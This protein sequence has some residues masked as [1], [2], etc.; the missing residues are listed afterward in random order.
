LL[1][2]FNCQ[3]RPEATDRTAPLS[4]LPPSTILLASYAT[5]GFD[6]GD[7]AFDGG[8]TIGSVA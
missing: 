1:V 2:L 5:V 3:F 8:I 4:D 6:A 7:L